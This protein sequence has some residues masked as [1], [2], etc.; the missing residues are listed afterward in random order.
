[1]TQNNT[2]IIIFKLWRSE[3]HTSACQ[4]ACIPSGGSRKES[5]PCLLQ[6][7]GGASK[8]RFW[9]QFQCERVC[10]CA[11]MHE[12]ALCGCACVCTCVHLFIRVCTCVCTCVCVRVCLGGKVFPPLQQAVLQ[13][14]LGGTTQSHS[15]T[16]YPDKAQTHI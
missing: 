8:T 9:S 13:Y 6:Q 15:D 4:Y 3:A 11:C 12:R 7:T 10:P 2:N 1:M 14:Q 16:V 5:F